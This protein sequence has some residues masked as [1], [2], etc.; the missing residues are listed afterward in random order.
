MILGQAI[1]LYERVQIGVD[2]FNAPIYGEP[3]ETVVDNVLIAPVSANDIVDQSE[4]EGRH[5]VYQLAIPKG[6]AHTWENNTVS[7]W[8][9]TWRVFGAPEQGMGEN[10]PLSWNKKIMVERIDGAV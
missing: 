8:G 3:T 10:I 2:S 1:T 6:D 7:F 9:K 5:E 4:L